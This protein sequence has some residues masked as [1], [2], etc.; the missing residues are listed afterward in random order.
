[1][2]SGVPLVFV[3]RVLALSSG[4]PPLGCHGP[5]LTL[6]REM[7]EE[8]LSWAVAAGAGTQSIDSVLSQEQLLVDI[9]EHLTSFL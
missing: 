3:D 6:T 2:A 8:P 4:E 1:M 7:H 9:W 5:T